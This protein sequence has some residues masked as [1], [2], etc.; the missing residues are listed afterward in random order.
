MPSTVCLLSPQAFRQWTVPSTVCILSSQAFQWSFLTFSLGRSVI[1][2]LLLSRERLISL[3][4]V[5]SA[6]DLHKIRRDQAL[7]DTSVCAVIDAQPTV[8][9][10]VSEK[11]CVQFCG[12]NVS[13]TVV[14]M[15]CTDFVQCRC[16]TTEI[17]LYF[18]WA[19]A[20]FVWLLNVPGLIGIPEVQNALV[21]NRGTS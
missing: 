6:I 17:T 13:Q 5:V 7:L 15:R 18:P 10:T 20:K 14:L 3:G 4:F 8:N 19:D 16:A 2:V 12:G 9:N 11:S 21:T 1:P